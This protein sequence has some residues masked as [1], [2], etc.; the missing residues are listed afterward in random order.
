MRTVKIRWKDTSIYDVKHGNYAKIHI[1][2]MHMGAVVIEIDKVKIPW[3]E[4][5]ELISI[6]CLNC[7]KNVVVLNVV[8]TKAVC[9]TDRKTCVFMV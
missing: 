2:A 3:G 4:T 9:F 1:V 8:A 5:A 7:L 6:G